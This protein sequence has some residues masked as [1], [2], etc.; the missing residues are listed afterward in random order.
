MKFLI[1][2]VILL[3][4]INHSQASTWGL[5]IGSANFDSEIA[6][7]EG[8]DESATLL[9]AMY[10][11]HQN[12]ELFFAV[13]LNIY[14]I[15]D[16]EEFTNNTTGGV[17][18]SS[19]S[20][21]GLSGEYGIKFYF[22]EQTT[23]SI[24]GG[25]EAILSASRSISNCIDCDSEDIDIDGGPFLRAGLRYHNEDG[26]SL[27]INASQFLN[28]EDGLESAIAFTLMFGDY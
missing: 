9:S 6:E 1:L 18:S 19:A 25:Y 24:T 12:E 23:F 14:L 2:T 10:E 7:E 8:I 4:A 28:S 3:L 27:G 11:K 21:G 26:Y 13:G 22:S 20:G 16:N 15:D 5:A 17:K